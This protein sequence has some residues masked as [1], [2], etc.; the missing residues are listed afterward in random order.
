MTMTPAAAPA[1]TTTTTNS[2]YDALLDAVRFALR[3]PSEHNAQPWRWVL[4]DDHLDLHVDRARRLPF[5]D[6]SGRGVLLGC[7]SA[8]HHLRIA[9]AVAGWDARVRHGLD[10]DDRP[11]ARV[12]VTPA[13][14]PDVRTRRQFAAIEQRH[15]DRRRF[16]A[17]AVTPDLVDALADAARPFGGALHVAVGGSRQVIIEAMSEAASAQRAH[18]GYAAELQRWTHRFAGARDGVPAGAR[19]DEPRT[20]GDLDLGRFP[21]GTLRQPRGGHDHDDASTILVLSAVG[22]DVVSVVRAGEALSAI[23]LEATSFGLSTTPIAQV[24]EVAETRE[25]IWRQAMSRHRRPVMLI[26]VGWPV[27]GAATLGATPRRPLESV[28]VRRT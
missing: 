28:L 18:E 27:R 22:D 14:A 12:N 26:R 21:S 5:T 24:L 1:A 6:H 16:S 8:L 7:G 3:A 9:L 11:L 19:P 2:T 17:R 25:R 4:D 20:Y 13:G 15:T 10:T 23:L